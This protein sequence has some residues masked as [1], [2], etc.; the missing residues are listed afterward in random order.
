[1][2]ACFFM[3]GSYL[4][5]FLNTAGSSQSSFYLGIFRATKRRWSLSFVLAIIYAASDE[6]HQRFVPGRTATIYDLGFDLS[7]INI[8]AYLIW[9]LKQTH[10]PKPKK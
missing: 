3:G 1:M 9:K 2:A 10:L 8:A 6:F 5:L 7:G 4:Y